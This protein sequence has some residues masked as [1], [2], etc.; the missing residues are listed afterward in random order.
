M[1]LLILSTEFPPGPGGIGT[2]AFQLS[3]K[4][5]KKGWEIEIISPQDYASEEEIRSF[6]SILPTNVSIRRLRHL[7]NRVIEGVYRLS[8]FIWELRSFHPQICIATGAQSV[9]IEAFASLSRSFHWVAIAH[10]SEMG[11]PG[12]SVNH[13][14]RWAFARADAVICVSDY[15]RQHMLDLGINS[16]H[17]AVIPNGADAIKFYPDEVQRISLRQKLGLEDQIVLLT[18]GSVTERKA[19]DIVIRALP[20]V[21]KQVPNVHYLIAGLPRRKE[22]LTQLAHELG[23]ECRVHFLGRVDNATLPALYNACDIFVL[24]SRKTAEGD[25]EGYGIAVVEAALCGKPAVVS[26]N[27]GLAEAILPGETGLLVPQEDVEAT[28]QAIIALCMDESLR[29]GMGAK[30][31]DRALAVQTWSSRASQYE[32]VLLDIISNQRK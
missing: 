19:Q 17:T 5:T 2:H 11:K 15:T 7:P 28:A 29:L 4:L 1:R 23:V 9:W 26:D 22:F 32:K 21:L 18:V 20:L 13:F 12:S 6:S 16:R 10:G 14:S 30:A 3:C 27:S 8:R 24:T 25:V 31:R